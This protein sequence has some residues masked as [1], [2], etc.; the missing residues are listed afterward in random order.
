MRRV[1]AFISA[2]ALSAIVVAAVPAVGI[3]GGVGLM[4]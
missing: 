3:I 2:V 4:N 1:I